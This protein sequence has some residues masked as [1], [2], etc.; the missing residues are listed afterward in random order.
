MA[1]IE[2]TM[3]RK[4]QK[5]VAGSFSKSLS[6]K[7]TRVAKRRRYANKTGCPLQKSPVTKLA[8]K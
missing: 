2:S 1:K 6:D 5:F 3:T 7:Q 4:S 8:P